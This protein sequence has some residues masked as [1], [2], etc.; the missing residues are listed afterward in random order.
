[1]QFEFDPDKSAANKDKHGIDVVQ[2]QT[3]WNDENALSV[4]A[5][6]IDEP[7]FARI[8]R[9]GN[10]I[11]VAFYTMR[12]G[13]IRLISVRRARTVESQRYE[14]HYSKRPR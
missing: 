3:L 5:T 1:M 13:R 4:P 7:R 9:L 11:W 12:N 14:D 10:V 2:A 6:S 8:S